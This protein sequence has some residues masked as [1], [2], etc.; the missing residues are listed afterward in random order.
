MRRRIR[1]PLADP[2]VQRHQGMR[3]RQGRAAHH[4]ELFRRLHELQQCGGTRQGRGRHQSGRGL[5]QRRHRGEGLPLHRR[6]TRRGGHGVRAQDSRRGGGTGQVTRRGQSGSQQGHRQCSLLRLCAH[7]LHSPG[8]RHPDLRHRRR[9][10]RVRRGHSRRA[11]QKDGK[12]AN[13]G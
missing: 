1:L 7:Q 13:G 5:C 2:G 9:R 11:G 6:Q 10:D 3:H 12:A 8:E 4:Q